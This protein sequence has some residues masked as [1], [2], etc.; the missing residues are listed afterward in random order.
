MIRLSHAEPVERIGWSESWSHIFVAPSQFAWAPVIF[1]LVGQMIS[2]LRCP[3]AGLT[4][5][6]HM[7]AEAEDGWGSGGKAELELTW[8]LIS[9]APLSN[10][11]FA[12]THINAALIRYIFIFIFIH[13]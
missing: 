10:S 7:Q 9:A 13:S 8:Q 6:S 4:S 5:G 1:I 11:Y 12:H 3:F 2:G